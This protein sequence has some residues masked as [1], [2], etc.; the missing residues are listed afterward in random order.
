MN[1]G[2]RDVRGVGVVGDVIQGI[3]G[4]DRRRR[5]GPPDIWSAEER[6]GDP[7]LAETVRFCGGDGWKPFVHLFV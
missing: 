4:F 2:G 1:T 7:A 6:D 3:I 5:L